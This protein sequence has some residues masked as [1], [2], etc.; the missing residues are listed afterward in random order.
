MESQGM[1]MGHDSSIM[2]RK[3]G[4]RG[5]GRE[6]GGRDEGHMAHRASPWEPLQARQRHRVHVEEALCVL[7]RSGW[8]DRRGLSAGMESHMAI[9]NM[10]LP[11]SLR[12]DR[13]PSPPAPR[14]PLPIRDDVRLITVLVLTFPAVPPPFPP[15]PPPSAAQH[16]PK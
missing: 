2:V 7:V 5:E 14:F 16:G 13:C 8:L 15:S 3:R 4:G 10:S 9:C 1:D 12:P 11:S 6:G